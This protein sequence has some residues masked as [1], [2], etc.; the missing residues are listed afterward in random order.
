MCTPEPQPAEAA[1]AFDDIVAAACRAFVTD[2]VL[3]EAGGAEDGGD[4]GGEDAEDDSAASAPTAQ[5]LALALARALLLTAAPAAPVTALAPALD[6]VSRA[7]THAYVPR[8]RTERAVRLVAAALHE[9]VLAS[10]VPGGATHPS[11][12]SADAAPSDG[13]LARDRAR[14][15]LEAV[16]PCMSEACSAA[17]A[18]LEAAVAGAFAPSP[19]V[20]STVTD[21][22]LGAWTTLLAAYAAACR[23][24]GQALPE[25]V[26]RA[27]CNGRATCVRAIVA[28][29]ASAAAS[30]AQGPPASPAAPAQPAEPS[31]VAVAMRALS[32][33]ALAAGS[34]AAL[35]GGEAPAAANTVGAV[36]ALPAQAD[37]LFGVVAPEKPA[38]S[39]APA[40]PAGAV[41]AGEAAPTKRK[42]RHPGRRPPVPPRGP[43]ALLTGR[44][45]C[46]QSIARCARW[47]GSD[48]TAAAPLSEWRAVHAQVARVLSPDMRCAI[49][50]AAQA[51][52][53]R[54]PPQALAALFDC[55]R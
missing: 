40:A 55:A 25:H 6:I 52:L 31:P 32:M 33:L 19:G 27:I 10:V 8:A 4:S 5:A 11:L 44:W 50:T 12:P 7:H 22:Q 9:L 42:R 53:P 41:A 49:L 37:E 47:L 34:A 23:R 45:L 29:T 13:A 43:A 14:C 2:G 20:A 15:L 51:E 21:A 28:T 39:T 24:L 26:T 35:F 38:K 30:A 48:T 3:T 36:L 16:T 1:A 17:E 18:D 46:L 54:A